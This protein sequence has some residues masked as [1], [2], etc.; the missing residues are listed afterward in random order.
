MT[1]KKQT[2]SPV[3]DDTVVEND[4]ANDP[5]HFTYDAVLSDNGF[6]DRC[7]LAHFRRLSDHRIRRYLSLCIY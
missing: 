7:P 6:L 2:H 1:C 4:A 5:D 3:R